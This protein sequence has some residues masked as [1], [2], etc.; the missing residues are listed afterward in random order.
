MHKAGWPVELI[1]KVADVIICEAAAKAPHVPTQQALEATY[2]ALD[3]VT[4]GFIAIN[5]QET[6]LAGHDQNAKRYADCLRLTDQGVG[7]ILARLRPNDMFIVTGDHGNDPTIGHDKHTRE[8]TPLPVYGEHV[9]ARPLSQ[10]DSLADIAATVAEIF[11]V[12]PRRSGEAFWACC[13][14]WLSPRRG[15]PRRRQDPA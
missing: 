13:S 10:R 4:H 5:V 11:Q 9:P 8:F 6:D 15:R 3:R 12:G 14:P 7:N 2:Q 1:G